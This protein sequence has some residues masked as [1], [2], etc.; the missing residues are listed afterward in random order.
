[1][2]FRITNK[3][4]DLSKR[5]EIITQILP[6]FYSL[7]SKNRQVFSPRSISTRGIPIIEYNSIDRM[8]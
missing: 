6:N 4:P 3:N 5:Y 1:M 7:K 2:K 8:K